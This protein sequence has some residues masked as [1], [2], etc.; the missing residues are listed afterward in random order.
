MRKGDHV[1]EDGMGGDGLWPGQI[2]WEA[3]ERRRQLVDGRE[4]IDR[5][6][7]AGAQME[8]KLIDRL[9]IG[10]LEEQAAAAV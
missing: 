1:G 9:E 3:G 8:V 4:Q 7:G 5:R 10:N 6:A 2:A